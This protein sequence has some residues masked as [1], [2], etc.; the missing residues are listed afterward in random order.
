[1]YSLYL[2]VDNYYSVCTCDLVWSKGI[3][4]HASMLS[5]VCPPQVCIWPGALSNMASGLHVVQ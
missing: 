4:V 3:H 5:H 1:M 2:R